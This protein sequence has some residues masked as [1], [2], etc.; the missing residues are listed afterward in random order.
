MN[1]ERL[2]NNLSGYGS[3]SITADGKAIVT[4]ERYSRSAVW[5]SPDLKPENTK[6]IMPNTGDTWGFP[7]TADGRIVY[8]SGKPA[9][10]RFGQWTPTERMPVRS[11]TTA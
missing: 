1:I 11:Q 3:L 5:V 2:T 10:R 6:Q 9:T 7:W 4:G 8:V